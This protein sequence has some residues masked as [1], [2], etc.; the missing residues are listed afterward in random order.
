[1]TLLAL[2]PSLPAALSAAVEA[3]PAGGVYSATVRH[4]N[5]RA[6]FKRAAPHFPCDGKVIGTKNR[7]FRASMVVISTIRFAKNPSHE[8]EGCFARGV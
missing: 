6:G 2:R 8:L 1:V 7:R 4:E 3:H 5:H